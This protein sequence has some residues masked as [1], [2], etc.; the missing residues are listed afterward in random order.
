MLATRSAV[1]STARV[2]TLAAARTVTV[3]KVPTRDIKFVMDEV[4]RRGSDQSTRVARVCMYVCVV[5]VYVCVH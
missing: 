1:R 5:C 4:R 3:F 2:A